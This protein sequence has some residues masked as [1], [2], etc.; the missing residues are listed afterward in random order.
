MRFVE[1]NARRT[2]K[3]ARFV[4]SSWEKSFAI[5]VLLTAFLVPF[6]YF[7]WHYDHS[8]SF[9]LMI[10]RSARGTEAYG[11]MEEEFGRG[12]LDP[13]QILVLPPQSLSLGGD[14]RLLPTSAQPT[15]SADTSIT[16]Q[17]SFIDLT[18]MGHLG[19]VFDSH[20]SD[21]F[22]FVQRRVIHQV[23]LGQNAT[24]YY[25]SAPPTHAVATIQSVVWL[26]NRSISYSEYRRCELP[27]PVLK[28][29]FCRTLLAAASQSLS[30]EG[31]LLV[32]V[33]LAVEPSSGRG[34]A[35]LRHTRKA[36]D[37][38]ASETGYE[39][40]IAAGA[41]VSLDVV[42]SVY[43]QFPLAIALTATVVLVLVAVAFQSVVVPL[44]ALF[45]IAATLCF[46][47]GS[48]VLVYQHGLLK[49]MG[50]AGLTSPT[51]EIFWVSP[52]MLFG[53]LCGISL[54][55]DTFTLIRIVEYHTAGFSE[56]DS[57][58]AGLASSFKVV[59]TA[60]FIMTIAFCG[61]LFSDLPVLNQISFFLCTAVLFDT[62]VVRMFYVP[63][64]MILLGRFN[65]FP[66]SSL[67][68][69]ETQS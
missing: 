50:I 67:A 59:T 55:Y 11:M 25:P 48:A 35:W 47:Y 18:S 36:L 13:Y 38:I 64:L 24:L 66:R 60:G 8:D 51:N 57:V 7:A 68:R 52:I 27:L 41:S 63:S 5:V 9:L 29:A 23:L 16:K 26:F 15:V 44:R 22:E 28:S 12:H 49:W 42:A 14:S 33:E 58:R 17:G 56:T 10:P 20:G 65:W 54:D 69:F 45:S 30:K 4:T 40:Y 19:T 43:E 46:V 37:T 62:F 3:V 39:F 1:A 21:I 34:Q 61:L 31:A 6:G 2:F 53:V 32:R